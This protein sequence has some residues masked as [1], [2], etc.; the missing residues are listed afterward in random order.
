MRRREFLGFS[1]SIF[2]G[3]SLCPMAISRGDTEGVTIKTLDGGVI[4]LDGAALRELKAGMHGEFLIDGMPEYETSRHIWN[5]A[6]DRHPAVIIRCA[7]SEDIARAVR[8]V[9]RHNALLSVRAGGHN[10]VGFAVCDGGVTIDLTRLAGVEVDA[11]AKAA[12]AGGGTT[13]GVYDSATHESGLASTGPIISMVGLGG[14]TLGGGIGW[15]HRKLG[16]GCDNLV[17]AEIVTADGEIVTASAQS[18]PDLFWAIRG[19]GGNFGIVSSFKYRLA[20]VKDVLAGLIFYRLEDLP[21]VAAHVREFNAGAPDDVCVWMMMR[22][23]PASPALPTE[24]HGRPVA[25]VA[26][27]W[28]GDLET[29]EKVVKPL[30]Q[31]GQPLID[32]VKVRP[33][34]DWQKALDPAWGNGFRNQW[35]GHYLPELTDAAAQT[36]LEHVSMVSSPFT[37]VKLATMGGAVARVGENDT[38]CGFRD[39]KYALVIQTR[40]KDPAESAQHLAWTQGFFDA[41]KPHGAGKVY[42]NFVADEGENRVA[43]A[44]N[45]GAMARLRKIKAKYDPGNLF[46]MNQNIRP[47]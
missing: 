37:D 17:S 45:A 44:Y 29:G 11:S 10:H 40:W 1:V 35:V 3:A 7:D 26:V 38:A 42:V 33:Y 14:Y 21:K 43:D 15:L 30:R 28:A 19:G 8:F 13:F 25:T 22:K 41:M 4:S 46:R 9:K 47:G 20:P 16:L 36:M 32:L 34:P 6:I 23:A 2:A 12:K 27:C 5:A 24:M 31:F 18:N 39:S